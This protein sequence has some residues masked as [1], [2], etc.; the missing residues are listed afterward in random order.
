MVTFTRFGLFSRTKMAVQLQSSAGKLSDWREEEFRMSSE[1]PEFIPVHAGIRMSTR[2]LLLSMMTSP[3]N[4]VNSGKETCSRP[5]LFEICKFRVPVTKFE[6]FTPV[7]A[8][9]ESMVIC[10]PLW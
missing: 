10:P 7:I 5:Q 6:M 9:L 4:T 2:A 1:A 3:P 8:W